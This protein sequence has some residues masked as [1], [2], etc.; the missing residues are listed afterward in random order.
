MEAICIGVFTIE[1]LARV[2]CTPDINS[3][4]KD[5]MNV[6]D[7]IAIFPFY[8]EVRLM[9]TRALNASNPHHNP[10]LRRPERGAARTHELAFPKPTT[11]RFSLLA[12]PI[13]LLQL[14][15]LYSPSLHRS[16]QLGT[17]TRSFFGVGKST[18]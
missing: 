13:T 18:H 9:Y 17:R 8:M 5:F 6:I 1:F 4:F 14:L 16:D 10:L 15:G 7:V 12:D 3:Y 11:Q 2:S